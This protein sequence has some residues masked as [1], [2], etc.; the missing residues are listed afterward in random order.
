MS[1][2]AFIVVSPGGSR[3]RLQADLVPSGAF[4]KVS[5]A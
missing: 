1:S 3:T 4:T 5:F 2:R